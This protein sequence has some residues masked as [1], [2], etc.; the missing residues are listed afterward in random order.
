MKKTEEGIQ[1]AEDLLDSI[2]SNSFDLQNLR[3]YYRLVHLFEMKEE[4]KWITDEIYGYK[5][6]T[7]LPAYRKVYHK[8]ICAEIRQDYMTIYMYADTNKRL[9]YNGKDKNNFIRYIHVNENNFIYII[10]VVDNEIFR[11]TV[12][13]LKKMKFEL[14][15]SDIFDKT[16]ENVNEKLLQICPDAFNKLT[17]TYEDLIESKSP[18]DLQQICYSCRLVLN[19][20]ADA[21][22]EPTKK[23][24]IGFDDKEHPVDRDN[25][26]NRIVAYVQDN[27]SSDTD[28]KLIKSHVTYLADFLEKIYKLNNKGTHYD[29]DVNQEYANRCV[30][31]TYL[32][33]GDIINLTK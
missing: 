10:K 11:K 6:S 32:I 19:D 3:K 28:K 4:I 33:L 7:K 18:L 9:T 15:E 14:I 25:Y 30:I 23:K 8:G 24:K 13:I 1:I 5:E 31:Y 20:F 29:G 17:E 21:L 22:Y 2:Y 16:R 12:N 26:V 27:I